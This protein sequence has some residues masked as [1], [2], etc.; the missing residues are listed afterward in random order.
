M[1]EHNT[2]LRQRMLD[3]MAIHNFAPF[4]Q[5]S[6]VRAVKNLA[7][8]FGAP[9]DTLSFEDV[10]DYRLHLVSRG[11]KVATINQIMCALR[12]FFGVTLKRGQVADQIP[13]ARKT[14]PLPTVLSPTDVSRFLNAFR[15]IKHRTVFATIYAAGLRVSEAASL[16]VADIDSARMVIHVRQGKGRKDRYVMLSAQLLGILRTYWKAVRPKH[17]LFPGPDPDRPITV[18]SLQRFCRVAADATGLD[19]SVTVHT[20]RHSFATHLLEQGVSIRVIQDLLGHR[21]INATTRYAQVALATIRQVQ[22]P[23]DVLNIGAAPPT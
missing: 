10:R 11:L 9:P 18:R 7:G 13:L 6:Y 23:L 2:P 4:T 20:L 8:Y 5:S 15:N 17:Y 1:T 19:K 21:H 16:T 14:E 12:F 3:D 22:S